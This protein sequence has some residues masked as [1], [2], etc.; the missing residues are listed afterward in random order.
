MCKAEMERTVDLKIQLN[1]RLD[2]R[3]VIDGM[4]EILWGCLAVGGRCENLPASTK[5]GM[6]PI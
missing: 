6:L 1:D 3:E 5:F 2:Q 4:V